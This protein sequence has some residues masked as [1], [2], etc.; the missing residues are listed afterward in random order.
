MKRGPSISA[1]SSSSA[2]AI[3]G[4]PGSAFR[5]TSPPTIP[6]NRSRRNPAASPSITPSA[7]MHTTIYSISES[8][9]NGRVI[10]VGTD[11]GNVQLTRDGGKTWTNVAGNV[12]GIGKAPW[13]SWVE[14]S[15]FAEG[16]AYATFDRHM[17][18]DM[19]PY[20]YKTADY[21]ATWTALP[22]G[23]PARAAT[24]TSSRKTRVTPS[25]LVPGHRIRPVDQ[26]GWRRA[27]GAVQR[28]AAFPPSRCA[29]WWCTRA[30]ATSCWPPTD[31]ASGSSTTSR[32][33]ARSRR[34]DAREDA[35]FLPV[36]TAVQWMETFGGWAEGDAAFSGPSRSTEAFIP[37][38]QRSRHIYGDLKIE[39]LDAQGKLV[40]DSSTSKHRGVSR[41]TWSMHLKPPRVPPA[42]TAAF[43]AA[44]GPRVLP[45]D[46]TVR[47]TR[48]EKGVHHEAHRGAGPARPI[49]RG[50]PQSAVRP[51]Q[52][53]RRFAEPHELGGGCHPRCAR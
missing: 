47:M 20:V 43:G 19:K 18:G 42:A 22:P 13:V 10:W 25:L 50:R 7:E 31:A 1:R 32:R 24:R 38:Y 9:L 51:G 26:R 48:G 46:Y 28:H 5:P 27:L 41:A 37:Y 4:N 12:T 30:P 53:D 52:P 45:G 11:D 16:T 29:T 39:I 3:T 33:G 34:T 40:D 35:G 6:K 36:P 21:G 2:R 15:R 49:H 14:A 8:P 44:V 17:Y 23:K